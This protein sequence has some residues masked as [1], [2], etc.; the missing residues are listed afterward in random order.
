M[1]ETRGH[2]GIKISIGTDVHIVA[3][4]G[5]RVS[6]WVWLDEAGLKKET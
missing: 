1:Y 2:M 6:E 3:E 4:W 5:G